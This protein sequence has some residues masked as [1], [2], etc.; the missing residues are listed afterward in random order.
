MGGKAWNEEQT[1]YLLD[2]YRTISPKD[3]A[4]YLCFPPQKVVNKMSKM[5]ISS[6]NQVYRL[7]Q[8]K[9]IDRL[10]SMGLGHVDTAELSVCSTSVVHKA[11]LVRIYKES[12]IVKDCVYNHERE[13]IRKLKDSKLENYKPDYKEDERFRYRDLSPSEKLIYHGI[14]I[15]T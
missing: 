6:A 2:N 11:D 12:P 15:N 7:Q 8:R 10:L 14:T 3:I 13:S 9:F 5:G 1:K 4:N